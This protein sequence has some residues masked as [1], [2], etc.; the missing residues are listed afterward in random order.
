ML[1]FNS[2][3]DSA[4]NLRIENPANRNMHYGD[5]TIGRINP[6]DYIP[7]YQLYSYAQGEKE[8]NKIQYDLYIDSKKAKSKS[9]KMPKI[10]KYA[11]I[12]IST[13][14]SSLYL[15]KKLKILK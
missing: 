15:G 5:Y 10:I 9:K 13:I 12:A 3:M 14:A 7:K 1:C 4:S 8:Y 6:P 2:D 11:F